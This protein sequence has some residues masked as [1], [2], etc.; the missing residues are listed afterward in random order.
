MCFSVGSLIRLPQK[1]KLSVNRKLFLD[2]GPQSHVCL[3]IRSFSE[4]SRCAH[5]L[6]PTVRVCSTLTRMGAHAEDTLAHLDEQVCTECATLSS[7]RRQ[8][9]SK[10]RPCP[11]VT[12]FSTNPIIKRQE[13]RRITAGGEKTKSNLYLHRVRYRG[14]ECP[15]VDTRSDAL[16]TD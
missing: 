10:P 14:W 6:H 3:C 16:Q 13:S 8:R 11:P 7:P 1:F 5:T 12:P 2:R 9:D 15:S 4:I